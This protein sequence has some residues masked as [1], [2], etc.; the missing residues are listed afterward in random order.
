VG[1]LAG[2]GCTPS[3][4][5]LRVTVKVHKRKGRSRARVVR[6]TFFTR[7]KGRHVRVDHHRPWVVHLKIDKPAGS[8]GRV[9]ARVYFRRA[10]H[11]RLHRTVVFRGFTVCA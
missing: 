7:G 1:L 8:H 3:G 4:G 6:V 10:K 9:Y 2:L 5:R 11:G